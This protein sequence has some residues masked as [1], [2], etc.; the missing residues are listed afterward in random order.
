MNSPRL[1]LLTLSAAALLGLSAANADVRLPALV[2]D[3]M[4][5]QQE[6]P[7]NVWGW[8]DPQEKVT[9][10]LGAKTATAVAGVDG[11]WSAKLTGLTPGVAGDMTIAGKNT[12]TIKNVA[13]GEVWVA[14]GQSNMEMVVKSAKD[15]DAET[16][17]ADRPDIR[18][19]TVARTWQLEPQEDCAGKWEICTPETVGHFSAVG[20][21]F[22]RRLNDDLKLPIGIIHSSVGGTPAQAWTPTEVLAADPDFQVF[23]QSW[24]TTK[25]NYP[26]AKAEYDKALEKWKT[27]AEAAKT[28]GQP[29]PRPPQV[30][31]GGDGNGSPGGLYN[32]MIAPLLPYTIRGA[33]WYQGE[34]NASN[35]KLYRKLFPAM[36]VSWREKWGIP[37][38]PFLFVQLANFMAKTEE[39][40]ESGWAEL[41]DAQL[42]TL[43]LKNTGM[44]VAIDVGEEKD[45][46][47]K[48]KQEVGRRLAL[49]ALAIVYYREVEYA[50][51]RPLDAQVED[52]KLR[53]TLRNAEGM[54]TTDGA[55]PKGFAI[56]GE[57][58]KFHWATAE[59]SGDH[60]ILSSPEV[61]KPVAVRYA[62]ANNP[63]VNLVN[64]AGLPVSPFRSDDWP[65]Q[66]PAGK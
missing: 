24:E 4:V 30:P 34:A 10:K 14:S 42:A 40:G 17:S 63:D 11:K 32:G 46:H 6:V 45:I 28:A 55:A 27:D 66:P 58:R 22:A 31:R 3:N 61:P 49:N 43:E 12:L 9:V 41:R 23:L 1:S 29:A 52:N 53:I 19:F 15:A 5:L 44:A 21:F 2:S 16:K 50:S 26:K 35:G 60:I 36:I 57:D 54:K 59:L 38:F 64:G 56:A 25:A 20:Y 65:A 8:A 39:P 47:P 7:A 62:W 48:N 13:V 33:I 18:M 37:E 51:P